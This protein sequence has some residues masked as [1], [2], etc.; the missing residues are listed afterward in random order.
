MKKDWTQTESSFQKFL[1]WLDEGADSSGEKYLEMRRRLVAYFDRKNSPNADELADETLA[2]VA[3]KL[4]EKGQITDLSP[5]HYCYITAK[6]V[7]L[8]SLRE[9]KRSQTGLEEITEA[10][11]PDLEVASSAFQK[12]LFEDEEHRFDC[13]DRCLKKLSTKDSELILEYYHGEQQEKIQHRRQLSEKLGL[14]ANALSIRACRIRSKV[15]I[16]VKECC[17]K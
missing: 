16:C 12:P 6:F 13:L 15:E 3:Q 14:S 7:F 9:A 8:E 1:R 5:A 11:H 2:R 4:E 17:G 10:G